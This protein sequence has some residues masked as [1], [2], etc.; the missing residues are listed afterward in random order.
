MPIFEYACQKCGKVFEKLILGKAGVELACPSCGSKRVEQ[1]ISAF[2]TTTAATKPSAAAA[3][4]T[5]SG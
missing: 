3:C 4:A 2:A 1:Q 5:G